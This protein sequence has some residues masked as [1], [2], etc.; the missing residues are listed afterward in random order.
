MNSLAASQ[1]ERTGSLLLRSAGL[2]A[3]VGG[4][5]NAFSDFLLQGG[6][7]PRAAVNT[8]EF[9]PFTPFD[10]VFLGSIIGNAAIPFWLLGFF[11][12]YVALAPAGSRLALSTVFFLGYGF[13]IFPGYHGSYA[14][15]AAGFQAH[16]AAPAGLTE[17]TATLVQRLHDYHDALLM[18]IGVPVMIGSILF[19][20]TVMLGRTL[21]SRWMIL[22]SPIIVPLTQPFIEMTPAPFGGFVRP[23]YGTLVFTLFFLIATI[24]TWN[25]RPQLTN[26][27][28]SGR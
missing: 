16:E 4:L 23:A 3:V 13:S 27:N 17:T 7:I 26:R 28:V 18:V 8:Y 14:L 21:F 25:V 24:V 5:A 1:A 2:L 11:P 15:Y 10:L 19:V 22:M 20:V 9:L 6:F 12:V